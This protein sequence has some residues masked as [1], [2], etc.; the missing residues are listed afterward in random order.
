MIFEIAV[1]REVCLV[2]YLLFLWHHSAQIQIVLGVVWV[3]FYFMIGGG[4]GRG[5]CPWSSTGKAMHF[6]HQSFMAYHSLHTFCL[7]F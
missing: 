2:H 3:E 6:F 5:L 7:A 1:L 4:S